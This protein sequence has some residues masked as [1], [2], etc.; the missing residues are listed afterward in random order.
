MKISRGRLVLA[1]A[2]AVIA[3]GA[4]PADAADARTQAR[5]PFAVGEQASYQVK[6][7]F[8]SVGSGSLSVTGIERVQGRPTFHTVMR[9]EGGN[10][11]Y[12]VNDRYE[13]WI[14]TDG[15]FSRRFHQNLREGGFRRNRTYEFNAAPVP[16][17]PARGRIPAE[18]H[19]RVQ[20][21][22]AHLSP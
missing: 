20:R 3:G 11:L 2:A 22:A 17:E 14:D 4:S 10:A 15:L 21:R 19:V 8:V 6:L 1:L 9:I 13:S 5:L 7:G 18:P 16:P 12:R